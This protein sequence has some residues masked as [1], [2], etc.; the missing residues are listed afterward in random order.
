ME[1]EQNNETGKKKTGGSAQL[2]AS[3]GRSATAQVS[4]HS[5]SGLASTGTNISY[6]G[7]TAPG[8]GG[9]V[10]TGFASGKEA[11]DEKIHTNSDFEQNRGGSPSKVKQ[12]GK[13]EDRLEEDKGYDEYWEEDEMRRAS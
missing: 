9:S 7:A 6:E 4:R 10:G 1:Q 12:E 3:I 5:G 11:V 13:E 8:A 2:A